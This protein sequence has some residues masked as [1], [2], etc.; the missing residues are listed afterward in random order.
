MTL[1]DIAERLDRLT[2]KSQE[3]AHCR[4]CDEDVLIDQTALCD[5]LNALR[6]DI[7]AELLRQGQP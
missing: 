3:F 5:A 2:M 1:K 7:E 6:L 4:H